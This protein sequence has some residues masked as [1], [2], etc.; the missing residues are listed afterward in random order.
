MN[1]FTV[2]F[3]QFQREFAF[4]SIHRGMYCLDQRR[5]SHA[6][7]APQQGVVCRQTVGKSAGY[8]QPECRAPGQ[9]LSTRPFRHGL[10][11]QPVGATGCPRARQ[12]HPMMPDR[13]PGPARVLRGSPIQAGNPVF[14]S[15][16]SF[17]HSEVWNSR[18]GPRLSQL[19]VSDSMGASAVK[20]GGTKS[21]WHFATC[22]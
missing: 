20:D 7:G 3:D 13:F 19:R 17:G 1:V 8:F 18:C 15:I 16:H 5:F 10:P 4:F 12:M 22:R 6:A 9:C 11:W 14:G 2:N 21:V